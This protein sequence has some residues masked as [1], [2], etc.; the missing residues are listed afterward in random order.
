M[1]TVSGISGL[2]DQQ[3]GGTGEYLARAAFP[4]LTSLLQLLSQRRTAGHCGGETQGINNS[5]VYRLFWQINMEGEVARSA[6]SFFFAGIG[7]CT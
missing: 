2:L 1:L 7:L 6:S 3:Y 5:L 4:H